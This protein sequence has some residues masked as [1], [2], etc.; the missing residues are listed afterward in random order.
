MSQRNRHALVAAT[1]TAVLFLALPSPSEATGLWAWNPTR[2]A[3]KAWSW[4]GELGF[5]P[6]EATT[7]AGSWEK[8]G[9]GLNPDGLVTPAGNPNP[10]EPRGANPR[11]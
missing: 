10:E 4:L 7:P 1:L 2:L 9:S 8:E 6:R 3:V 5:L 11:G